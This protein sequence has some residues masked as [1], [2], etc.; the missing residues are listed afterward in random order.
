MKRFSHIMAQFLGRILKAQNKPAPV[1]AH[2]WSA[3][4][5]NPAFWAVRARAAVMVDEAYTALVCSDDQIVISKAQGIISALRW[6][7]DDD[8]ISAEC[9]GIDGERT[10]SERR[11]AMELVRR[12]FAV[13]NK[14]V[15]NE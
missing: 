12:A 5:A 11:E 8:Q 9:G 10:E 6:L 4:F 7:I 14:E 13:V 3:L 15:D 1:A 2:E